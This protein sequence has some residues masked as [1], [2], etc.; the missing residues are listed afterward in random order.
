MSNQA[1]AQLFAA[2]IR[3][4]RVQVQL[5]PPPDSEMFRTRDPLFA[6]ATTFLRGARCAQAA[7]EGATTSA[8]R[9]KP[10]PKTPSPRNGLLSTFPYAA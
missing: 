3:V 10:A 8:A 4:R 5:A 7:T 9:T 2:Q 1:L 6:K